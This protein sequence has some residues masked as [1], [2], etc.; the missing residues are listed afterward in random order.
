M[1]HGK[2]KVINVGLDIGNTTTISF[3][4]DSYNIVESR[5]IKSNDILKLSDND[6]VTL[7]NDEY[8]IG[9]GEYENNLYKYD[10]Q[11]FEILFKYS[12]GK[13]VENESYVNLCIGIPCNQFNNNRKKELIDVL[14][15]YKNFTIKINDE[16]KHIIIENVI[17]RPEGYPVYSMVKA[18]NK[19]INKLPTIVIDIGG[20]T[21]D[22]SNYDHLGNFI[23]GESINLGL[24]ELY[25]TV[26]NYVID[27]N[28]NWSNF[29]IEQSK[30]LCR[31]LLY[32]DINLKE[33]YDIV[34]NRIWNTIF[35]INPNIVNYNVILIG[36][37]STDFKNHF[38]EK[39]NNLIVNED[40]TSNAKGF[41]LLSKERYGE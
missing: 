40:I 23:G 5:V 17:I 26:Q 4:K 12:I 34:F 9:L 31:G 38:K 41:Y 35:G 18:T 33:C 22:I 24:N 30:E 21:T 37:G 11:N 28:K 8:I 27:N 7:F 29:T 3:S 32:I 14:R 36:G 6:K 2:R 10:K 16:Y 20:G 39:C 25:K 13:V 19:L 15:K 1:E